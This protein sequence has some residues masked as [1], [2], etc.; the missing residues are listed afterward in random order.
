MAGPGTNILPAHKDVFEAI[1][2]GKYQ[3][4][5]LF[6]C[7]VNDQPG[8]AIVAINQDGEEYTITPLFVSVAPGMKL[9]DH[10][11]KILQF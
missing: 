1:T 9:A 11:G 4:F 10:D 5:A 2:S 8:C 6:S 7:F 3:N